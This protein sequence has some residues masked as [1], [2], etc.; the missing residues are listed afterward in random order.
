VFDALRTDV[1]PLKGRAV[2]RDRQPL[3]YWFNVGGF[4]ACGALLGAMSVWSGAELMAAVL[5][6]P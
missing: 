1:F 5:A 6:R 2:S 4:A 3:A